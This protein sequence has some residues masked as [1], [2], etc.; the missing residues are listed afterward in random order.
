MR[1]ST[2]GNR[3]SARPFELALRLA[4]LTGVLLAGVLLTSMPALGA[5]ISKS[6]DASPGG[7]LTINAE[8]ASIRVVGGTARAVEF[9][10]TR[11]DE[12]A[13]EIEKDF[14]ITFDQSGDDVSLEIKKVKRGWGMRRGL[15]VEVM[16][17]GTFD[18]DLRSSG[19]SLDV[20]ELRGEVRVRTSGGS[21]K[22]EQIDGSI[23]GRTSGGSISIGETSGDADLETSG[24][25]IR[26]DRVAGD[27]VA[28]TSGGS[29]TINEA[30]GSVQAKTSG[31]GVKAFLSEQPSGDSR[32]TT[33][34][35]S[36]V[37]EL[38]EG[39]SLDIDASSSGGGVKNSL[40]ILVTS[41]SR[42]SL[43]GSLNGGGPELYLR[44]SGGSVRLES[45]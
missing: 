37:V 23:Y 28:K 29:I 24:G 35:G 3:L 6:F 17:P 2:L 25:S 7:T 40:P 33:S 14:R 10:V 41:S 19:G 15:K 8:A 30:L 21:L 43:R 9:K 11:R 44:S 13:A 18:V 32:L 36:V 20:S 38:A 26:I 4:P 1:R 5:G 39:L 22:L 45:R 42:T 27:V 31:G 34:G 12:S 16:V